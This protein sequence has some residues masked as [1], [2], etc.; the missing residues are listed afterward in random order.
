MILS[1]LCST[2]LGDTTWA[3]RHSLTGDGKLHCSHSCLGHTDRS[4]AAEQWKPRDLLTTTSRQGR[5]S[6]LPKET[7]TEM[8]SRGWILP[9]SPAVTRRVPEPLSLTQVI[10]WTL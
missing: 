7:T 5:G 10:T 8:G 1:R 4:K 2:S 3:D 6:V 9:G